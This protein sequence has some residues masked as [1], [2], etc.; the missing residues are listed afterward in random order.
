MQNLKLIHQAEII[1]ATGSSA[2]A[3]LTLHGTGTY[4]EME[5]MVKAGLSPMEVIVSSTKNGGIAMRNKEI[6]TIENGKIADLVLLDANPL[7]N[8]KNIRKIN[9][10]IKSGV[11]IN[12]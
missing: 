2:G 6:G 12:R 1:V 3:P 10:V 4:N 11:I 8:I 5:A 7:E 9:T